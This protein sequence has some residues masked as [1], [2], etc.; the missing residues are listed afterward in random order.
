MH[1]FSELAFPN[2]GSATVFDGRLGWVNSPLILIR[3]HG[4][5]FRSST[6]LP[7]QAF[8][9]CDGAT[10]RC[11]LNS[12]ISGGRAEWEMVRLLAAGD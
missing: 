8:S 6:T 11:M 4:C 1:S 2:S 7:W 3:G 5:R 10:C 12:E 9:Q